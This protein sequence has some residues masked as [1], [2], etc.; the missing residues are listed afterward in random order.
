[1]FE[2]HTDLVNSTNYNPKK[3]GFSDCIYKDSVDS[4]NYASTFTNQYEHAFVTLSNV[5]IDSLDDLETNAKWIDLGS[6]YT[7]KVSI[8]LNN[9]KIGKLWRPLHLFD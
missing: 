8:L 7:G 9:T 1:M 2:F 4:V 6:N 3:V 5:M